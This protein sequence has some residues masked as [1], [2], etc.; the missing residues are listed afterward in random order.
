MAYRA[1]RSHKRFHNRICVHFGYLP[2][3]WILRFFTGPIQQWNI[4]QA[5]NNRPASRIILAARNVIPGADKFP[6]RIEPACQ[7]IGSV[8]PPFPRIRVPCQTV[9]RH[10]AR[11]EHEADVMMQ[12]VII[13]ETPVQLLLRNPGD[14]RILLI[15]RRMVHLPEHARPESVAPPVQPII[16]RKC[17]IFPASVIMNT[18][19]GRVGNLIP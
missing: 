12:P 9:I 3:P 2:K 7:K 18:V 5:V 19:F 8:Q 1:I 16:R 13:A 6:H 15:S 4:K 11:Q 10:C 14:F 17:L